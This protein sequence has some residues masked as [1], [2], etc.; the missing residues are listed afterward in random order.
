MTDAKLYAVYPDD[1]GGGAPVVYSHNVDVATRHAKQISQPGF[2]YA[3]REVPCIE[4]DPHLV[5][6]HRATGL[7]KH[8]GRG[9]IDTRTDSYRRWSYETDIVVRPVQHVRSGVTGDHSI[10]AATADTPAAAME[11]LLRLYDDLCL[12]LSLE[13]AGRG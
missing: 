9:L 1:D 13:H 8:R 10:L 4:Q 6:V 5:T 3:V 7:V 11:G 12:H 2:P